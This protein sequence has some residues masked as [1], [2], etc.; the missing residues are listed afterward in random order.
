MIYPMIQKDRGVWETKAGDY[1]WVNHKYYLYEV[2]VFSRPTG[3]IVTNLVTDPY[4]L[5]LAADSVKSLVVDLNSPFTKP[6]FWNLIPKPA[7]ASPTDIVLYEL[8]IRD[9]SISDTSVPEKD[10]GKYTA[11]THF[12]SRGMR[13]LRSM[14]KA[15]LTHVH[16]LPSFD[17]SSVPEL[18][19]E[20]KTPPDYPA[21]FRSRFG[22]A[23][24]GN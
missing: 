15:G 7:L 10:R 12:F 18:A 5:G 9:F 23:G 1:S 16:L 13:H 4:S 22:T 2:T 21:D 24:G 11:F 14:A 3:Q 20:Q 6:L 8:H 17:F 19:S